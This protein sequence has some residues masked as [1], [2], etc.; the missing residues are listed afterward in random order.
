[1]GL[2]RALLRASCQRGRIARPRTTRVAVKVAGPDAPEA[3]WEGLC[4]GLPSRYMT[5]G[6]D[7]SSRARIEK[8]RYNQLVMKRREPSAPL[9]VALTGGPGG[10]KTTLLRELRAAD[11]DAERFVCVPEAATLLL[12]AGLR[13]GTQAFQLGIVAVQRALEDAAREDAGADRCIACDRGIVDSLA[14]WLLNGWSRDDFF[15]RTG[16]APQEHLTRYDV[17]IHL[18]TAAVGAE[19]HYRQ[20][21]DVVRSEK[22][23]EAAHIDRII[24]ELWEGHPG[25]YFVQNT[26]VSW[27]MKSEAARVLINARLRQA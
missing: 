17:A 12:R 27:A 20:H 8:T 25:Y 23:G 19:A 10:G 13:Q 18:Q 2:H 16:L 7:E 4:E 15:D 5:A 11:P 6:R 26:S 14:Y 22:H 3:R 21:G 24:A 1:M 9:R